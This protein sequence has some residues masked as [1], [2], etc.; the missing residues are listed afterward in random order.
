MD[1]HFDTL[2]QRDIL[3][4][5]SD[6]FKI[7][8]ISGAKAKLQSIYKLYLRFDILF[9]GKFIVTD[10]Q[11]FDGFFYHTMFENS[12]DRNDFILFLNNV[13]PLL[14]S[15][16][17]EIKCRDNTLE[18]SFLQIVKSGMFEFATL[19]KNLLVNKEIQNTIHK[20]G[21]M[22]MANNLVE[23]EQKVL[24]DLG[25]EHK[26]FVEEFLFNIKNLSE[27]FCNSENRSINSY[28]TSP[29]ETEFYVNY[30]KVPKYN[31]FFNKG[32]EKFFDSIQENADLARYCP[33][34]KEKLL[35]TLMNSNPT[36]TDIYNILEPL[37]QYTEI[38][39]VANAL[40]DEF[41][42]IYS[43][44]AAEQHSCAEVIP[45][46]FTY[47]SANEIKINNKFQKVVNEETFNLPEIFYYRLANMSW[48]E[49]GEIICDPTFYEKRKQFIMCSD[50]YKTKYLEDYLKCIVKKFYV[51]NTNSTAVNNTLTFLRNLFNELML[52]FVYTVNPSS[53][54]LSVGLNN[55]KVSLMKDLNNR[56]DSKEF[57][58]LILNTSLI[59]NIGQK[60]IG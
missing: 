18:N 3:A 12:Q 45:N 29:W 50:L 33:D 2:R 47:K 57:S 55:I 1:L 10:A 35:Q 26:S 19:P 52:E 31:F 32:K 22:N 5:L 34:E 49:F 39:D 4:F 40:S 9:K 38:K 24:S 28:I 27:L 46:K 6:D 43:T 44:A 36:R 15:D 23:F 48:E 8:K 54:S 17:F 53:F 42:A 51:I 37:K 25:Y 20:I 60:T 56:R 59:N 58:G 21:K 13:K 16:F 11:Y 14:G 30:Q 41:G 7:A